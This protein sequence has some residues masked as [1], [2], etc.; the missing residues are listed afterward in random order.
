MID[1]KVCWRSEKWRLTEVFFYKYF[2]YQ[3]VHILYGLIATFRACLVNFRLCWPNDNV[4][5]LVNYKITL[6]IHQKIFNLQLTKGIIDQKFPTF[7]VPI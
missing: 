3:K 5:F 1:Q 6:Q 2:F 4:Y 7:Y